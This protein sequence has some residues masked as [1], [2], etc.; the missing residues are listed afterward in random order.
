MT[1]RAAVIGCG[2]I[3]AG[4][5]LDQ[6]HVG[7]LSHCEAYQLDQRAELVAVCDSSDDSRQEV[8]QRWS[9]PNSYVSV[10]ELL[11]AAKPDLVSICT[12]DETHADIAL[13]VIQHPGVRG[14]LLEKPVA[15]DLA[16]ATRVVDT[17]RDQGVRLA[18]NY[19][20][21]FAPAFQQ[22]R[23]DIRV[24][25]FGRPQNVVGRY[26]KGL[27]HNGTHWIDLLEFLLG[28]VKRIRTL[29]EKPD[30]DPFATPDVQFQLAD[31]TQAFLLGCHE[32][33]FT[34][35]EMDLM[36]ATGRVQIT[37]SGHAVEFFDVQP[38]PYYAGYRRLETRS[39]LV[40]AMKSTI[41]GAV[42]NLIG[43]LQDEETLLC[44]GEQGVRVLQIAQRALA[45]PNT[46]SEIA[47]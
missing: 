29:S 12:P 16:M 42:A 6:E 35:F 25:R 1:M 38:S 41:C 37:D 45:D 26:T 32:Q 3:G 5:A 14:V 30:R 11:E 46:W 17:A 19:S 21:R 31:G 39:K 33:A 28:P 10:E 24:G 8:G 22:L 40:A 13:R 15:T 43:C 4:V 18:V 47:D 36:F 34:V 2:H 7:V 9:V 27:V 23:D 44:T 20:R